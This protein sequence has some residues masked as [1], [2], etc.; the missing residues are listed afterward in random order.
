MC[1][2]PA[3]IVATNEQTLR[4]GRAPPTR[5]PSR[6]VAFTND[7]TRSRTIS[8]AG[9][10]RPAFATSDSSSKVTSTRS[11]VRDTPPT[12]SASSTGDNDDVRHRHRPSS[13]GTFRGYASSLS[14]YS[15][16]DRGLVGDADVVDEDAGGE[17][18][19]GVGGS[20]PVAADREV[21]NDEERVVEDPPR[22]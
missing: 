12:G 5:P 22:A 1:E 3:K 6:T 10:I 15:S 16:V 4:P 18:G 9:T 20:G 11:I 17:Y 8:V 13:G 19:G 14:R 7:S 2:P 21:E